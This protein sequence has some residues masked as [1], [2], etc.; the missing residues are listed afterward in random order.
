MQAS[1]ATHLAAPAPH[2]GARVQ[3]AQ[4][5]G[6]LPGRLT[7]C[8]TCVRSTHSLHPVFSLPQRSPHRHSHKHGSVTR[9]C[10][11]AKEQQAQPS[12]CMHAPQWISMRHA[13]Q[14]PCMHA[15]AGLRP[16][17]SMASA[18]CRC[19]RGEVASRGWAHQQ[20]TLLTQKR[21]TLQNSGEASSTAQVPWHHIS[22]LHRPAGCKSHGSAAMVPRSPFAWL[23]CA[24]GDG[25]ITAQH[26][27]PP[28]PS[29]AW[30]SVL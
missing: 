18:H 26:L 27:V 21:C 12:A 11:H 25:C 14:Y 17:A 24:A 22:H 7:Q 1:W 15:P 20:M 8:G 30:L 9:P 16:M 3:A 13:S 5:M 19:T 4:T 28:T 23:L 6:R 29:S 2:P 10:M